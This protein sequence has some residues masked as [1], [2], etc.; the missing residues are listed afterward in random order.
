MQ[1]DLMQGTLDMLVLKALAWEPMHGYG[2]ARWLQQTTE[3]A[4]LVEEGS[5]YPALHRLAHRGWVASEW[6]V[7]E[8]NRRAKYYS[9]TAAG[10]SQLAQ[11]LRRWEQF[12]RA[13]GLVLAAPVGA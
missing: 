7:S 3:D 8:H 11:E 4:L 5:L 1:L 13:V 9:L 10:R 6:G 12:T 2:L